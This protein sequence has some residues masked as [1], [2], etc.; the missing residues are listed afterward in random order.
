[1]HLLPDFLWRNYPYFNQRSNYV[2]EQLTKP[3]P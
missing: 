2:I 1:M 3:N